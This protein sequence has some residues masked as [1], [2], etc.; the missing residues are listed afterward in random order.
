MAAAVQVLR[1]ARRFDFEIRLQRSDGLAGRV[2]LATQDESGAPVQ[3][4]V[5]FRMRTDGIRLD[6]AAEGISDL[7]QLDAEA[8]RR[9]RQPFFHDQVREALD[10]TVN[11]F[12]AE[13]LSHVSVAALAATAAIRR[14]SLAEAQKALAS[15]RPQAA[16]RV[17]EAM[18]GARDVDGDEDARL[19]QR[20][21][22]L[23]GS[24]EIHA[25]LTQCEQ[26]LWSDPGAAFQRLAP[27]EARGNSRASLSNRGSGIHR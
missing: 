2:S 12:T 25:V 1:Y 27:E 20:I 15:Q 26:V 21:T 9:L 5:G 7:P 17:L 6:L 4:A 24:P 11:V 23:C 10:G 13:W 14:C 3:Q 19:I 18:F 16:R 8:M 22:A